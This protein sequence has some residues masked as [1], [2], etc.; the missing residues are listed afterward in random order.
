MSPYS[1]SS[2]SHNLSQWSCCLNLQVVAIA[3]V[4]ALNMQFRYWSFVFGCICYSLAHFLLRCL[5]SKHSCW[6]VATQH[7][8]Q[9]F[10]PKM[11]II[12]NLYLLLLWALLLWANGPLT[13]DILGPESV[14]PTPLVE[15]SSY[16]HP[17]S[18]WPKQTWVAL[19]FYLHCVRGHMHKVK[20]FST[21]HMAQQGIF[22]VAQQAGLGCQ[23]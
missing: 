20:P 1:S 6:N 16:Q 12:N 19:T 2:R 8:L 22:K 7:A 13:S 14:I 23:F 4:I 9:L 5:V 11:L 18:V 17:D 10:C 21:L 3:E 15:L